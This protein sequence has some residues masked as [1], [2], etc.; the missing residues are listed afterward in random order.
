MLNYLH[1][2]SGDDIHRSFADTYVAADLERVGR[3]AVLVQ[4]VRN[5]RLQCIHDGKAVDVP[6]EAVDLTQPDLGMM[7]S[8]GKLYYVTRMPDRQWRRGL[9][10]RGL[11]M[12][13]LTPDGRSIRRT[14]DQARLHL[15]AKYF[16]EERTTNENII[17]RDFARRGKWLFFRSIPVGKVEEDKLI[18]GYDVDLARYVEADL[19]DTTNRL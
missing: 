2:M 4:G 12:Y 10:S 13:E 7:W 14:V 18:M 3:R 5:E 15:I 16:L 9:R 6:Y 19:N 17:S 11:F 1:E 8:M